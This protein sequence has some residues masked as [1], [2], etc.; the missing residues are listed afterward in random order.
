MKEEKNGCPVCESNHTSYE[1]QEGI[2][3]IERCQGCN[4]LFERSLFP[5]NRTGNL[6][7]GLHKSN[8]ITPVIESKAKVS[9][10]IERLKDRGIKQGDRLWIGG[11]GHI[12]FVDGV[13]DR[14]FAVADINLE[15]VGMNTVDACVLLENLGKDE[16]PLE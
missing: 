12:Q 2:R 8:V 14:G 4:V 13:K 15:S 1:F 9:Q 10:C 5:G 3:K 16:Y 7:E 11:N 6:K